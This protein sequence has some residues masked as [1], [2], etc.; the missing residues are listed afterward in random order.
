M[1]VRRWCPD[2]AKCQSK[3][4]L[5]NR[6]KVQE[7][8]L[9]GVYLALREPL[10]MYKIIW[11]ADCLLHAEPSAIQSVASARHQGSTPARKL[12]ALPPLTSCRRLMEDEVDST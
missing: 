8:A 4:R 10:L 1:V 9:K 3:V 2:E 5:G 12:R 7:K 11:E 6:D